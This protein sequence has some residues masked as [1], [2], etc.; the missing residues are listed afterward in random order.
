[1]AVLCVNVFIVLKAFIH[2][3]KDE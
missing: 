3:L 1:V 2:I